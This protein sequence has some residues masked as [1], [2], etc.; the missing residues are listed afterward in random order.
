MSHEPARIK[1]IFYL[2]VPLL[3]FGAG[4]YVGMT[5]LLRLGRTVSGGPALECIS[6]IDL[7][8]RAND[9]VVTVRFSIKNSGGDDL[10]ISDISPRC[11]CSGIE[12]DSDSATEPVK[13]LTLGRGE[14]FNARMRFF[15][16]GQPGQPS[17]TTISMRTNDPCHPVFPLQV[18][19]AKVL[20]GVTT[21]PSAVIFGSVPL[22]IVASQSIDVYDDDVRPRAVASIVCSEPTRFAAQF[23]P[24]P[25]AAATLRRPRRI[26]RVDVTTKADTPG[27]LEGMIRLLLADAPARPVDVAVI[28]HVQ[29]PV[30]V[31]PKALTL[32]IRSA[33]GF[34]F[35]VTCLLKNNSDAEAIY[36][37]PVVEGDG[38]TATWLDGVS[39][40]RRLQ[41]RAVPISGPGPIPAGQRRVIVRVTTQ[42]HESTIIIPVFL[43]S[44]G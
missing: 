1:V 24:D 34:L 13:S 44:P 41:I 7:G 23:V 31:F 3:L 30:E 20:G 25:E 33:A 8:E 16:K 5:P 27:P 10:Y 6:P 28:G 4:T 21:H 14:Q 29:A 17:V 15:V 12:P 35:E 38:L 18:R 26:G 9:E 22:G 36:G 32:P 39:S 11:S 43:E 40:W 19:V 37:D 2:A 42:S